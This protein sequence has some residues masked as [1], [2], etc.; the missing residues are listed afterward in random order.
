[1]LGWERVEGEHVVFGLLEHG[2]DLRQPPFELADRLAWPLAR[3]LTVRG[4]EDRPDDRPE[5]VVLV[6][7]D[8]AAQVAQEVHGAA[9]PRG[10]EQLR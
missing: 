7:A 4:G 8:V 1:V 9:L 5:R 3:L 6:L 10:A 2:R